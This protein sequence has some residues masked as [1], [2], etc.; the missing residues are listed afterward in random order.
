LVRGAK[1]GSTLSRST[2]CL[3]AA[4]AA[5][6]ADCLAAEGAE[7]QENSL[8]GASALGAGGGGMDALGGMEV[9]ALNFGGRPCMGAGGGP[10]TA[11]LAAAT[12][13]AKASSAQTEKVATDFLGCARTKACARTLLE[14]GAAWRAESAA[15]L[16]EE[17]IVKDMVVVGCVFGA[18]RCGGTIC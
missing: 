3:R 9:P 15:A 10:P 8:A 11:A 4:G 16:M 12:R 2:A 17:E 7:S 18:K 14:P 5:E 13:A 1:S 6:G